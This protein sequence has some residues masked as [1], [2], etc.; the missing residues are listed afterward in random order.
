MLEH[1]IDTMD[2]PPWQ[3]LLARA[4]DRGYVTFRDILKVLP[5]VESSLEDMEDLYVLLEGEGIGVQ[6]DGHEPSK[7]SSQSV[8]TR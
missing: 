1:T 2:S 4:R 3:R 5:E 6:E 7:T 8:S